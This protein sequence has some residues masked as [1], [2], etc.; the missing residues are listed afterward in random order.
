MKS[1]KSKQD[2]KPAVGGNRKPETVKRID[3]QDNRQL[4]VQQ[5]AMKEMADGSE[6]VHKGKVFQQKA[7]DSIQR[8]NTNVPAHGGKSNPTGLPDTLK[9]GIENLSGQS[10]DDVRVHKNSSKPAQ[11]NAHAYAQGSDIHLAAGQ[12]KHLPHEAW[13]VV[14]QKQGRVKPTIKLKGTVPVNDDRHLENEADVMGAKAAGFSGLQRK[15]IAHTFATT[16]VAQRIPKNR[17]EYETIYEYYSGNANISKAASNL[18][19]D[20]HLY[21]GADKAMNPK[22]FER[23]KAATE[24]SEVIASLKAQ[25]GSKSEWTFIHHHLMSATADEAAEYVSFAGRWAGRANKWVTTGATLGVQSGM[26]YLMQNGVSSA[27]FAARAALH[28]VNLLVNHTL[29]LKHKL[30]FSSGYFLLTEGISELMEGAKFFETHTKDGMFPPVAWKNAAGYIKKLRAGIMAV[31]KAV[32]ALAKKDFG[33]RS[34]LKAI[35]KHL[36]NA[37]GTVELVLNFIH[38]PEDNMTEAVL[39]NLAKGVR[40]LL[41]YV[42]AAFKGLIGCL[43]QKKPEEENLLPH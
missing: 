10:M 36:N 12:E 6:S 40:H 29:T 4:T 14:Q 39:N 42:I 25:A 21:S 27:A 28:E 11:L 26:Q 2:K 1:G 41:D 22:L 9:S 7:D 33:Y 16:P 5:K 24:N 17:H 3:F 37:M 20:L 31:I 13:H 34:T 38:L 30:K 15:A 32:N 23:I 19:N 8:K 18:I 35:G 43:T